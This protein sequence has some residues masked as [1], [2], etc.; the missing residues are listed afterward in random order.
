MQYH[1]DKNK[2]DKTAES[3]FKEVNEAYQ[4]L[5]DSKKREQYDMFGSAGGATGNPFGGGAGGG[6]EDMFSGMGGNRGR[7]QSSS[8]NM[9][10]LFGNMGGQQQRREEPKK[11]PISLDFEKT[12]EVPIF[13]LILGCSIEV[14]GVYGQTK[15]IK[16]PKGT[17][18]GTKMRVKEFGKSEGTKKGNLLITIDAKMPKSISEVDMMMLERIREG[19]GY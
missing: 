13:D 11:E 5:S 7:G 6:F 3:K 14:R 1:P 15:N 16:I 9:E 17:K 8:F 4:T 18:P 19:V 2:G 12:Y 10:D